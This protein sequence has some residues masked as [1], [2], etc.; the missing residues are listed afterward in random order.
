MAHSS[1]KP[2]REDGCPL[3]ETRA[4]SLLLSLLVNVFTQEE[5]QEGPVHVGLLVTKQLSAEPCHSLT[6]FWKI[7]HVSFS[8]LRIQIH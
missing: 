3:R 7:R 8:S 6:S 4:L 5:G 2:L 1:C